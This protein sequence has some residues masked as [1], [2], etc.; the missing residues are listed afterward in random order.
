MYCP[1]CGTHIPEESSICTSCG[2]N[3]T[4]L[5]AASTPAGAQFRAIQPGAAISGETVY[6]GF[7]RRFLAAIIDSIVLT[8]GSMILAFVAIGVGQNAAESVLFMLINLAMNWLYK[9]L[10]ESSSQQATLGKM[11][12]GIKVTD[13]NGQR[14][15]FWRASGRF[16]A[17]VFSSL[18]LGIGFIMAGFTKRRQA[19]HDKVAG[20]LVVKKLV[21]SETLA[22]NPYAQKPPFWAISLLIL[23]GSFVPLGIL[24]AIAIPAY[25]DYTIRAQVFEGLKSAA[26]IQ[27]RVADAYADSGVWPADLDAIGM[28]N[29]NP[30]PGRYVESIKVSNGTIFITYGNEANINIQSGVVTVQPAV[31]DGDDVVW[32]CGYHTGTAGTPL[33]H[34]ASGSSDPGTTDLDMKYLPAACRE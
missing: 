4:E 13:I 30:P 3:V 33:Y 16:F 20:T 27:A 10:M 26:A 8:A 9:A 11:A 15:G 29:T 28:N 34:P 23:A 32:L 2:T 24:A 25:Q 17:Q 21:N 1:K 7:W 22:A 19:L 14:I 6:A 31:T 5:K 12:I 18:S